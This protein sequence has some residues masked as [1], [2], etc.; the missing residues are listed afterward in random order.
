MSTSLTYSLPAIFEEAAAR[1]QKKV[2]LPIGD[3]FSWTFQGACVELGHVLFPESFC[4]TVDH[5]RLVNHPAYKVFAALYGRPGYYWFGKR[6]RKNAQVRVN[7]LLLAAEFSRDPS[8]LKG[9]L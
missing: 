1:I 6:D 4:Y 3:T 2:D 7:A 8:N 9:I 5:H